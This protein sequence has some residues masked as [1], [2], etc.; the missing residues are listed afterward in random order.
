MT[1]QLVTLMPCPKSQDTNTQM[2]KTACCWTSIL[3]L[4]CPDFCHSLPLDKTL[5]LY[6]N[7]VN[8]K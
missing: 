6:T 2:R 5:A 1:L 3:H 8:Q 4:C 7:H